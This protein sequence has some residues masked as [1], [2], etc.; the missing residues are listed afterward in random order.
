M[1]QHSA[2][3]IWYAD[4]TGFCGEGEL[5]ENSKFCAIL[6][7]DTAQDNPFVKRIGMNWLHT[8]KAALLLG[9]GEDA[10]YVAEDIAA[11]NASA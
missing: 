5:A 7:C 1:L 6:A 11:R 10:A 4:Y 3:C 9:V 8:R 2:S